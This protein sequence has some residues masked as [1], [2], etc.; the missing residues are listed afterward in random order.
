MIEKSNR[1][2]R[3]KREIKNLTDEDIVRND[4]GL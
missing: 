1:S 3:I 4:A 2:G